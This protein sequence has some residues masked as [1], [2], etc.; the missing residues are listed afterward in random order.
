MSQNMLQKKHFAYLFLALVFVV[1]QI[2]ASVKNDFLPPP[3]QLAIEIMGKIQEKQKTKTLSDKEFISLMGEFQQEKT[4]SIQAAEKDASNI[5]VN[6]GTTAF[7]LADQFYLGAN[8]NNTL[9]DVK[10]K[11]LVR[12]S[13]SRVPGAASITLSPLAG[14]NTNVNGIVDANNKLVLQA[15]PLQSRA[16]T[17]LTLLN[18]RN[19]VAAIAPSVPT[20][21][22]GSLKTVVIIENM[23]DGSSVT[24]NQT[25]VIQDAAGTEITVPIAALTASTDTIFAAVAPAVPQAPAT[26]S[27]FGQANSGIV[28]L[29]KSA[30][31]TAPI[32]RDLR[33]VMLADGSFGSN[34][35]YK[36]DLAAFATTA[37]YVPSPMTVNFV[38]SP[39]I[40]NSIATATLGQAVDMYWDST[41]A[42]LYIA[43]SQA[44]GVA[45]TTNNIG[46]VI[47]L[48]VGRIDPA[49]KTMLITPAI[50]LQA[51]QTVPLL[52][53]N[54]PDT[55][56]Q[57]IGFNNTDATSKAASLLKVRVMHTST[58]HD[59]VIVN[60]GVIGIGSLASL[61][62]QVYALPVVPLLSSSDPK[63]VGLLAKRAPVATDPFVIV[64]AAGDLLTNDLPQT[65]VGQGAGLP[66]INKTQLLTDM[67]I[68]GD[69][70]YISV[71]GNRT[72]N[73]QNAGIFASSALF[74]QNGLIRSW[75][76]WQRVMGSTDVVKGFGIDE[77]SGNFWYLTTEDGE[78][79]DAKENTIKVTQWGK[80]EAVNAGNASTYLAGKFPQDKAG[81]HHVF[82]YS[83]KTPG[84]AQDE[85]AMAVAVG[86]DTVSLYQTGVLAAS[87]V[88]GLT[89]GILSD[90]NVFNFS[91]QTVKAL[92]PITSTELSRSTVANQGW[93]FIGGYNGVG[94]LSK[95]NGDGFNGVTG[96]AQ[97]GSGPGDFPGT[98]FAFRQL[99]TPSTV[100]FSHTRK[101]Q[102]DGTNLF[103]MTRDNL[104]RVPMNRNSFRSNNPVPV[105]PDVVLNVP[106][107]TLSDFIMINNGAQTH[108]ILATTN[109]LYVSANMGIPVKVLNSPNSPIVQLQYFSESREKLSNTGNL[110]VLA[111]D[112]SKSCAR[113]HRFDVDLSGVNPVVVPVNPSPTGTKNGEIINFSDFKANVVTDGSFIFS[114][115]SRHFNETYFVNM[116]PVDT[117]TSIY[118][119]SP[120]LNIPD[121]SYNVGMM[122]RDDASGAW[123]V[124]LDSGI[125]VNQ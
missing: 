27:A 92:G 32:T 87:G 83:E 41:L 34:V 124:P 114:E 110:Y 101:L 7:A 116:N 52:T 65:K 8:N 33:V 74:D 111:A 9:T 35:A 71:S 109:G 91:D 18:N 123:I 13:V 14:D 51:A 78:Q 72:D 120:L 28:R 70:V 53:L 3:T 46:G 56:N 4:R 62:T 36:I 10:D 89:S 121:N 54:A 95:L 93:L 20:V 40:T 24:T 90:A 44:T 30:T 117:L 113:L 68:V 17:N 61:N 105:A 98:T 22:N 50:D 25:D 45:G 55:K 1:Q 84:F 96:L 102:S 88:L 37:A 112:M 63:Q 49:T 2:G 82:S 106:G 12:A 119:I 39:D 103:V 79:N 81:V 58:G 75:T 80:T 59:Y 43:L 11:T 15:S 107:A 16:I 100:S 47:S 29:Q 21:A 6:Y 94:V 67:N 48:L 38:F 118:Q 64:S 125:R 5:K 73:N 108:V 122:I 31:T 97:L 85:F 86:L 99:A 42:R 104:Y 77:T 66:S 60:G 76:P 26:V 23:A 115:L 57:I 69:T 19:P